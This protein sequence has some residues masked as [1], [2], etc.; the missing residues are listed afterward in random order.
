MKKS[1]SIKQDEICIKVSYE[2]DT[3][4]SIEPS[5][6]QLFRMSGRVVKENDKLRECILGLMESVRYI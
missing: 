3:I 5:Y 2:A 6:A 4:P 1:S